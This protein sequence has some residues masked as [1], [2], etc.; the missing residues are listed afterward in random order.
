MSSA[1][2]PDLEIDDSPDEFS[3]IGMLLKLILLPGSVVLAIVLVGL[4][5]SW[6]TGT[7]GDFLVSTVDGD[8]H[9]PAIAYNATAD[10]HLVVWQ[11]EGDI[12]G[13]IFSATGVPQGGSFPIC[14]QSD[15]QDSP[16][17]A[18]N[19]VADDYLVVW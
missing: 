5:F 18:Y 3:T 6:A 1:N 12:Y 7:G 13:Q 9:E 8:Q 15:W 2:Q 10:E 16:A 14:T 4:I 17:V 11:D 19:T